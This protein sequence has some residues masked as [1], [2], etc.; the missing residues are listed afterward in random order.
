MNHYTEH[1]LDLYVRNSEQIANDRTDIEQHLSQ[2]AGCRAVAEDLREFYLLAENGKKQLSAHSEEEDALIVQPAYVRSRP[3]TKIQM[4]NSIPARLWQFVRKRPIVGSVSMFG[5]VTSMIFFVKM[6]IPSEGGNPEYLRINTS[7]SQVEIYN[8]ESKLMW[9]QSWREGV[10]DSFMEEQ[11]SITSSVVSDINNDGKNE[12]ISL[13]P[14]LNGIETPEGK[15]LLQVITAD[16]KILF[17]KELGDNIHY[18][19]EEYFPQFSERGVIVDDFDGDGKKE[20]IVGAPHRHSPYILYRLDS[21]GNILGEY[22]H[23]G[24]FWGIY[25]VIL[26]GKKTIVACGIDDKYDKPVVV[27]LNPQKIIGKTSSTTQPEFGLPTTTAEVFQIAMPRSLFDI[28][29]NPK[30]RVTSKIIETKN[31]LTFGVANAIPD[32]NGIPYKYIEYTFTKEMRIHDVRVTDWSRRV[33]ERRKKEGTIKENLDNTYLEGLKTK[34]QYWNGKQ[35]QEKFVKLDGS[36]VESQTTMLSSPYY[37]DYNRSKN[38]VVIFDKEDHILW[39]K[40]I[41]EDV[42]SIKEFSTSSV[43]YRT[44]ID[45]VNSDGKKEVVTILNFAADENISTNIRIFDGKGNKT[46][47]YSVPFQHIQYK[48]KQYNTKFYPSSIVFGGNSKKTLFAMFGNGRSPSALVRFDEQG[49]IIGTFWHYGQCAM[50]FFDIDH[51]GKEELLLNGINDTEDEANRSFAVTIV[52]DPDK[53]LGNYECSSTKG[54]N[55]PSSNAELYYV[56]YPNPE[57]SNHVTTNFGASNSS[58]KGDKLLRVLNTAYDGGLAVAF[59]YFFDSTFTVKDVK[60]DSGMLM[61]HNQLFK[62]G[63]LKYP[64]NDQYVNSLKDSLQYWNGVAWVNTPT[65]IRGQL[66]LK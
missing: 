28:G 41:K 56:R 21:Q 60:F 45:D 58:N 35:W 30:P 3:L 37:Y 12:I 31:S 11:F 65:K 22:L 52:L 66:S 61:K 54:F 17:T 43:I 62:E 20:I 51:D 19:Q 46:S 8:H 50:T 64:I 48:S 44:L 59:E 9:S 40:R 23:Y 5:L 6:F 32:S 53:I 10:Y 13:I 34:I 4:P 63:K 38:T 24:H 49:K 33:F 18:D 57:V 55:L 36:I 47:T 27:G 1:I 42:A 15:V 16:K 39:E 14:T 29:E 7:R 26:D 25:N 2:C